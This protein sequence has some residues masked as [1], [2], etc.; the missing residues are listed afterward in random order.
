MDG[1]VVAMVGSCTAGRG[2]D[3]TGGGDFGGGA[4]AGAGGG[5]AAGGDASATLVITSGAGVASVVAVLDIL[6][7]ARM[8]AMVRCSGLLLALARIAGSSNGAPSAVPCDACRSPSQCVVLAGGCIDVCETRCRF[9]GDA[10][11]RTGLV[12]CAL[13]TGKKYGSLGSSIASTTVGV[14]GCLGAAARFVRF[15]RVFNR[16]MFEVFVVCVEVVDDG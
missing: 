1:R 11:A 8:R 9:P 5:A 4:A 3:L 13:S 14:S 16:P 7:A 10:W 15:F 6:T 2:G 12:M